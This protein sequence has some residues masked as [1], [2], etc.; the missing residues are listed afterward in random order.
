MGEDFPI[1]FVGG[2][3]MPVTLIDY[4][5]SRSEYALG[6][7]D[8][9]QKLD[10]RLIWSLLSKDELIEWR[11]HGVPLFAVSQAGIVTERLIEAA[12]RGVTIYG[13]VP[14]YR[15]PDAAAG[16]QVPPPKV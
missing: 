14:A 16:D 12:R 10:L 7:P 3:T 8:P 6:L 4:D 9:T 2:R 15:F 13:R 11:F 5:G 1:K